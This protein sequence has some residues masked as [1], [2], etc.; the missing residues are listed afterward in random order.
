MKRIRL[1]C[2]YENEI[3]VVVISPEYSFSQL[4]KRLSMDYGF[5]VTLKY[6]DVDGDMITL[7]SQNDLEDLFL[8]SPET[9]NVTV[10]ENKLPCVH[11]KRTSKTPSLW[12]VGG[13]LASSDWAKIPSS[14]LSPSPNSTHLFSPNVISSLPSTHSKSNLHRFPQIETSS[15]RATE[16]LTRWKKGEILG[17]G[18]F[19]V[20]CLGLN[21]ETGELMAVKQMT[22]DDISK[23]ELAQLDNEINTLR[24]LRHPNIVRYIGTEL[25]PTTLSV[26]LEYV[27]GGSLKSLVDK[28]GR[29]EEAVARSYTRQL[30]LGLEYLHRN[31]IAHRDV[32]GANCLVGNDGAIKLADFGAS[33]HWRPPVENTDVR[34]L[35]GC[36]SDPSN[37]STGSNDVRGTPS[38][39]APE[40]VRN[41]EKHLNWKKADVWSLGC[42]TIEMTTGKAPWAQFN[43]PVTVLYH[44]AC[45]DTL[46]EYPEN[47]SVELLTFLNSCLQRDAM[48]RPDITSLL[49]HPFVAHANHSI[50]WSSD[51][52]SGMWNNRPSTVSTTA[53]EWEG[54]P[55]WKL[56]T[57]ASRSLI[58]SAVGS[59]NRSGGISSCHS[60]SLLTSVSVLPQEREVN[61]QACVPRYE[62]M[63][64]S[65]D[66]TLGAT[67]TE[68]QNDDKTTVCDS[69]SL[70]NSL[71]NLSLENSDLEDSNNT[72]ESGRITLEPLPSTDR[73]DTPPI[74]SSR[75]KPERLDSLHLGKLS[76]SPVED[77][78]PTPAIIFPAGSEKS[79][80][81]NFSQPNQ[82]QEQSEKSAAT[83]VRDSLLLLSAKDE[84]LYSIDSVVSNPI[85]EAKPILVSEEEKDYC[86]SAR[87]KEERKF[88]CRF[89]DREHLKKSN[90]SASFQSKVSRAKGKS[91]V[92]TDD[93]TT[94]RG[95]HGSSVVVDSSSRRVVDRS[96]TSSPQIRKVTTTAKYSGSSR[97]ASRKEPRAS[98][99][100]DAPCNH[101]KM[102]AHHFDFS[103]RS[104]VDRE[105]ITR[106]R[107]IPVKMSE[108]VSQDT[109][110]QSWKSDKSSMVEDEVD[111]EQ[112]FSHSVRSDDIQDE[113]E[114]YEDLGMPDDDDDITAAELSEDC[115]EGECDHM[116][117]DDECTYSPDNGFEVKGEGHNWVGRD[118]FEGSGYVERMQ[119]S[120]HLKNS[121][122]D[123]SLD[124]VTDTRWA[125]SAMKSHKSKRGTR[126]PGTCSTGQLQGYALV[127]HS[128]H[129]GLKADSKISQCKQAIRMPVINRGGSSAGGNLH[130]ESAFRRQNLEVAG[131]SIDLRMSGISTAH[132]SIRHREMGPSGNDDICSIADEYDIRGSDDDNDTRDGLMAPALSTTGALLDEHTAS[133]SKLRLVTSKNLL[134]SASLD[135]TVRVWSSEDGDTSRAVLDAA[136]FTTKSSSIR[137]AGT[138]K[139]IVSKV[140]CVPSTPKPLR[141]TGMWADDGCEYIWGGCSDGCVRVWSGCEGKPVRL[142]KGHGELVTCIE[143]A[144]SVSSAMGSPHIT[145][146][147]SVDRTVR[148]W[149]VRA[150]RSQACMFRGHSDSILSMKW[151]E[152]G[153]VVVSSSKDRTVKLWDIRTGRMRISLDKHFG[154]VNIIK[155][156][157]AHGG[158]QSFAR[159]SPAFMS[160]ARDGII[161]VW[162]AEGD[163]LASHGAHRNSVSCLSE[164]QSYENSIEPAV[165]ANP[166]I[167]S[168][169]ADGIVKVWDSKRL[170]CTSEFAAQNI[171][172]VAWFH[173]SIITGS[174]SGTLRIWDH[175]SGSDA[176]S[177]TEGR[178]VSKTWVSKD[179]NNFTQSCTDIATNK[180]CVASASKSGQIMRWT[181]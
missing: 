87:V 130:S 50:S 65:L 134:L 8:Y 12:P 20:V 75:D 40:V 166:G 39:M 148:V 128:L 102:T 179:L 5:D 115:D 122:D 175:Y 143:G 181:P 160:A 55:Q 135:G 97:E 92:K 171:V 34:V 71:D 176:D 163:C 158:G 58:N 28:F 86:R 29:L 153:R 1:K 145:A 76:S 144:E 49:L 46:P 42:T 106:Q 119:N 64:T 19:G 94:F 132:P 123:A 80:T 96:S 105:V 72:L 89:A 99:G 62:S 161:N 112:L 113:A 33:K 57:S 21:V 59:E 146:T 32:K 52:R 111:R 100:K 178:E 13:S 173:Q 54:T 125:G 84:N 98:I 81:V 167:L 3:R 101:R 53:T 60:P 6:D 83:S 155:A 151:V 7:A 16:K 4:W 18:A 82:G 149:D 77:N 140:S 44:I 114:V 131:D 66:S 78:S 68:Q 127:G 180:Y 150:K 177:M 91:G 138:G 70:G 31:G 129:G 170:K 157:P 139:K 154:S 108:S 38:F 51:P 169:G 73:D 121:D 156:I 164:V 22:M 47:P 117:D 37:N 93:S 126:T 109:L 136:S 137:R 67:R 133:V 35:H 10:A 103:S 104:G 147:G 110:S 88:N 69:L 45:S 27:P 23:K 43:N 79:G 9:V 168:S 63:V 14:N 107:L 30:L 174:S 90:N 2:R 165:C 15:P 172:K 141:V 142:M 120:P 162:S 95:S 116:S 152:G 124:K 36:G 48:N 85:V 11:G 74:K 24:S 26:F 41:D 61:P 56:T 17:K 118:G 159:G 25:T